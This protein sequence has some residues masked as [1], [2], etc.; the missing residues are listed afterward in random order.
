[1]QKYDFFQKTPPFFENFIIKSDFLYQIDVFYNELLKIGKFSLLE[2]IDFK[3]NFNFL[4]FF[5]QNTNF[6]K[7]SSKNNYV[8][9]LLTP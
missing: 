5:K 1:M 8:L 7:I 3:D 9:I 6:L 4:Y 2:S